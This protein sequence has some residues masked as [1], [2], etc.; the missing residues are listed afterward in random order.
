MN[1]QQSRMHNY[2]FKKRRK[3]K[4]KYSIKCK[5]LF[6][7][8]MLFKKNVVSHGTEMPCSLSNGGISLRRG[9]LW[10]WGL[11]VCTSMRSFPF[12]LC[13]NTFFTFCFTIFSIPLFAWFEK[14]C[15]IFLSDCNLNLFWQERV[16]GER[17]QYQWTKAPRREGN[18]LFK[19]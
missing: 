8:I 4:E 9:K 19:C 10:T 14:C 5:I 6:W 1:G 3:T 13:L 12:I 18:G 11:V 7:Y 17:C 2:L 15:W 16:W